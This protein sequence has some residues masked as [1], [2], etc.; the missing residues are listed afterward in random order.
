MRIILLL[1]TPVMVTNLLHTLIGFV[2]VNMISVLGAA[3]LASL[4]VNRSSF[5]LLSSV[6]MGLGAG[7]I[8]YVARLTGAGEHHKARSYATVGIVTAIVLGVAIAVAGLLVGARPIQFMVTSEVGDLSASMLELTRRYAWDYMRVILYGLI[9]LGVQFAAVSVFNSLGRT[10]YPMWLLIIA[11]VANFVGNWLLIERYQVA[12]CAWSTTI[13]TVI[14]AGVA[15]YLLTR[16]GAIV[17]DRSLLERPV[18][19]AL[20]MLWL[21]FPASLQVG[22][23][24]LAG[25]VL[26]KIITL[27]PN[28]VVGQSAFVVGMMAESLAFMP[29]FAFSVA[30][31]TLTGQNL[32]ARKEGQARTASLYCLAFSQVIMWAM[33][34]V[35]FFHPEWFIVLFIRSN[36]PEVVA[37][38]S[39]FLRILALCFPGLGLGMTMNGVLRGA[40]DTRAAALITMT[41][42]WIVR[43]PL[44]ALLA[45]ENVLG[46]GL[47][48]GLGL[49]GIWWGMTLSVYVEASLAYWRFNSGAWARIKLAQS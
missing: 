49:N 20:E 48:L 25:L 29:G 19:R 42:Q 5:W 28:S 38:A 47:G 2:D 24:A 17:W 15:V 18:R 36:A 22:F 33:G 9:G 14:V 6:F 12:G 39:D 27:L 11:N 43:I 41:A 4:S 21:G 45:F 46:T 13:T 35:F 7:I 10:L 32:G 3:A 34:V 8:A 16:Q 26:I 44:V 40:G 1:A 37:P 31:A 23:R 30:A